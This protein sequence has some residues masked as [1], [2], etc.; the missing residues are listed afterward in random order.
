[1]SRYSRRSLLL[2]EANVE[3]PEGS[4]C[5]AKRVHGLEE[6]IDD[7]DVDEKSQEF[8]TQLDNQLSVSLMLYITSIKKNEDKDGYLLR[9]EK[10]SAFVA[11]TTS[12]SMSEASDYFQDLGKLKSDTDMGN[13]LKLLTKLLPKGKTGAALVCLA[14][15]EF[16]GPTSFFM[17][18]ILEKRYAMAYRAVDAVTAHFL[19]IHKETKVMPVIWH[20]TLL[21]FVLCMNLKKED[22]QSLGSLLDKQNHKLITPEIAR[23]LE[24]SSNRREKLSNSP[25]APTI[26]K[27]VKDDLFDMPQVPMEEL[28]PHVIL[29][30]STLELE[31]GF[32]CCNACAN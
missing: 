1:M 2:K 5:A 18:V 20:Q 10:G 24:N 3:D 11:E 12:M 15:L 27:P 32:L 21:A 4:L 23:E 16:Y 7:D 29:A 25:S 30:S 19:R 28:E 26:Y 8:Q 13:C 6:L 31:V 9:V 22:K 17:K 14:E